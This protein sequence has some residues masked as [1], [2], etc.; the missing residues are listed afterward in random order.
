MT[1]RDDPPLPTA[2]RRSTVAGKLFIAVSCSLLALFVCMTIATLVL[3]RQVGKDGPCA[4]RRGE[5]TPL[6]LARKGLRYLDHVPNYLKDNLCET[7]VRLNDTG[8]DELDGLYMLKESL[9]HC[10]DITFAYKTICRG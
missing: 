1:S 9:F 3:L 6:F 5:D 4:Q 10:E 8:I 7:I 2:T